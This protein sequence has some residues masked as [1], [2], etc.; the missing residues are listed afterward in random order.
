MYFSRRK[1]HTEYVV[2]GIAQSIDTDAFMTYVPKDVAEVAIIYLTRISSFR[3]AQST[4]DPM[5]IPLAAKYGAPEKF[6]QYVALHNTFL[7]LHRNIAIVRIVPD[8]MDAD[9]EPG[10]N[11]RT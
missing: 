8:A 11:L 10:G 6:G 2:E 9:I 3:A 5:Y 7:N 1:I 4:S